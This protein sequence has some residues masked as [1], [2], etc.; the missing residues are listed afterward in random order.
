M[1]EDERLAIIRA[2]P[3]NRAREVLSLLVTLAA[4]AVIIAAYSYSGG[5]DFEEEQAAEK[6]YCE[7]VFDG[8]WPN[9]RAI[10]CSKYHKENE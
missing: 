6:Y 2:H 5:S 9:Y 1:F 3:I 10:D 8:T 7:M 4:I